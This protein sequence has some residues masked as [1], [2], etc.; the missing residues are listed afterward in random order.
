MS[1]DN[2]VEFPSE[3][4]LKNGDSQAK[5]PQKKVHDTTAQHAVTDKADPKSETLAETKADLEEV[6]Q[7][8]DA[9]VPKLQAELTE[10]KEKNDHLEDQFLRAQAEIRNMA[11][12]NKKE[13]EQLA[14]YDGQR[15]AKDILPVLDNLERALA[16]EVKDDHGQQLK[17]GIEMVYTAMQNAL[18]DNNITEIKAQGEKFDPTL[19]QAVQTT[20]KTP[21]QESDTVVQVLQRGYLLK[22]RVLRPAMVVVAQ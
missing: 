6:L 16:V 18:K 10:L 13:Q 8:D 7:T 20:P 19:H 21:D 22:D 2:K 11:N 12:R 9:N 15:L 14:K 5:Q 1:K 4:D 3:K 17:K